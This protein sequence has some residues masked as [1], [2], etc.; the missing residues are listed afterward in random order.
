MKNKKAL[1]MIVK[2]PY[3]EVVNPMSADF[4]TSR[5]G[6]CP[7]FCIQLSVTCTW[8]NY[9]L[10]FFLSRDNPGFHWYNPALGTLHLTGLDLSPTSGDFA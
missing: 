5:G 10:V 2:R 3:V 6:Q 8:R 7:V 9:T 1:Y 4:R